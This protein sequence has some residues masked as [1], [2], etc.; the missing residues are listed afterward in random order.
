MTVPYVAPIDWREYISAGVI[1]SVFFG[2]GSLVYAGG[3]TC[4]IEYGIVY[5]AMLCLANIG[6]PLCSNYLNGHPFSNYN[7]HPKLINWSS[8]SAYKSLENLRR[9]HVASAFTGIL[10]VGGVICAGNL[11]DI[12]VAVDLAGMGLIFVAVGSPIE[13]IAWNIPWLSLETIGVGF[14]YIIAGCVLYNTIDSDSYDW[15]RENKEFADAIKLIQEGKKKDGEVLL[16]KEIRRYQ[17]TRGPEHFS[18]I[19][20]IIA[21]ASKLEAITLIKEGKFEVGSNVID[22]KLKASTLVDITLLIESLYVYAA[23]LCKD[24]EELKFFQY[25]KLNFTPSEDE[26]LQG[27]EKLQ[28]QLVLEKLKKIKTQKKN[29]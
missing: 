10:G 14:A 24:R 29:K 19:E 5:G 21:V 7:Y 13:N 3:L 27:R 11:L 26:G 1:G 2:P 20:K 28:K 23:K 12:P 25:L 6:E 15:R 9:I 17:M 8:Y 16:M 4:N 18:T 22:I